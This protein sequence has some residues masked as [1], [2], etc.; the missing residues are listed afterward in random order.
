MAISNGNKL[1]GGQTEAA[2]QEIDVNISNGLVDLKPGKP[3]EIALRWEILRNSNG[4]GPSADPSALKVLVERKDGKLLV[5]DEF[6]GRNFERQPE[7][8]LFIEA[9]PAV[10]VSADLGNGQLN[11]RMPSIAL[12]SLG[13]GKLV[14]DGALT[15]AGSVDLGNG[16]INGA[17]MVAAGSHEVSLG[18]GTIDLVFK[19]GSSLAVEASSGTG[20][21]KM[22]GFEDQ[23]IDRQVVGCDGTGRL[24][25]GAAKLE[26]STG[27]GTVILRSE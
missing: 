15:D 27:N 19:Q 11:V 14:L 3:G 22:E 17:L 10:I 6:T 5:R 4:L 8:K 25:A 21:V 13:N 1:E 9:D 7:L 16:M 26:V 23:K 20:T 2:A 24:G 18:N 12:A